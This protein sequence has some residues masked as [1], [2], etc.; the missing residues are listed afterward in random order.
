MRVGLWG[1][2]SR[3][4]TALAWFGSIPLVLS[5]LGPSGFGVWATVTSLQS[6][7]GFL[8]LGIGSGVMNL[9]ASSKARDDMA[10]VRRIVATGLT[11]LAGVALVGAMALLVA[12]AVHPLAQV[13]LHGAALTS[14]AR[15][16]M[17][18]AAAC[19]L[20]GIPVGLVARV[21]L[22]LGHG[23]TTYRWQIAAQ[24]L[25]LAAIWLAAHFGAPLPAFVAITLGVPVALTAC[26]AMVYFFRPGATM[27]LWGSAP[28]WSLVPSVLREGALFLGMQIA[29]AIAFYSDLWLITAQ[30]GAVDAGTYAVAARYFSIGTMT[31][32]LFLLPLWPKYR[33]ALAAGD[34]HWVRSTFRQSM[35]LAVAVAFLAA[36]GLL[37]V[38]NVVLPLWAGESA[39]RSMVLLVGFALWSVAEA[40]GI[41]IGALLNAASILRLQ[42]LLAFLFAGACVAAR[43]A[44][45]G[46]F[47]INAMP[48]AT[49]GAYALFS[50]GPSLV[51]LPRLLRSMPSR[52]YE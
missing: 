43:Y 3:A 12:Q 11:T 16:S 44:S 6:L 28:S 22:G 41:T 40:A 8:D 50:L 27:S 23:G 24:V 29:A 42:L 19:I 26:N 9:A 38:A 32:G 5:A 1:G 49:L 7:L 39:P 14:A 47:G 15:E 20:A 17:V 46:Y 31:V 48:W 37:A 35:R 45:L 25:V 34:H 4:A 13:Q 2:L 36:A 21:Q 30:V 33:E 51:L 18:V 10:R 52:R